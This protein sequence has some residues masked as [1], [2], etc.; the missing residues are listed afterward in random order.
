MYNKPLVPMHVPKK[1]S[2]HIPTEQ[3]TTLSLEYELLI[4]YPRVQNIPSITGHCF[5]IFNLF[6]M[7]WN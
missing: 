5:I 4:S 3:N 2:N 6:E 1:T 7:S